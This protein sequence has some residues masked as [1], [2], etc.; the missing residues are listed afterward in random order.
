MQI[1]TANFPSHS[2]GKNTISQYHREPCNTRKCPPTTR[3]ANVATVSA[4][5]FTITVSVATVSVDV[6]SNGC[7]CTRKCSLSTISGACVDT[8]CG[9]NAY[10]SHVRFYYQTSH[11]RFEISQNSVQSTV[12]SE[13]DQFRCK[14]GSGW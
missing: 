9:I 4:Y 6:D 5:A 10:C 1:A 7:N 8:I 13:I 2:L 14:I 3:C 12:R 11:Y